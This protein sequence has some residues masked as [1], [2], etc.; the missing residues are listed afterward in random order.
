MIRH[1]W[2]LVTAAG[3]R[4]RD[5]HTIEVLGVPGELLMESAG[6]SL[7]EAVLSL[8]ADRSR[9]RV[10]AG[11]GNNGGDGLV[12]ARHLA[13]A[14]VPVRIHLVGDPARMR[15][16]AARNLERAR[17]VGLEVG[18][19]GSFAPEAAGRD[20]V[21]DAVF[22]TG[23]ARPVEGAIAEVLR[24]VGEARRAGARVVAAD[25]PSGLHADTGQPLGPVPPA[26]LTVT[27]GLPKLGLALEPGRSL[28]GRVLVARI[29]IADELPAGIGIPT[30]GEAVLPTARAVAAALPPR[31][32]EGHKGR[33]GHVLVV[34]GSPGKTGAAALAA[35]GAHRA[36][37]GLVTVACS[38]A[39]HAVLASKLTEAMT[40]PLPAGPD[41]ALGL[42]AVGPVLELAA[43]RD[44]VVLGPG[45]GRGEETVAAVRRLSAELPEAVVI[46]ADGLFALPDPG[47]LKGRR[48]LPIVT[49]HPGE[50]ARLLGLSPAEVNGDRIGAAARLAEGGGAVAL[51]KGA[52]TVSAEPGG[53]IAVNPT[54]GPVLGTG[55]TGDVLA[56]VVGGL[57]AQ[58]LDPFTAAWV[59]AYIHGLAGDA[60]ARRRGN[61]GI[62]AGE[63]ADAVPGVLRRLRRLAMTADRLPEEEGRD[64]GGAGPGPGAGEWLS[65]QGLLLPFPEPGGHPLAG[66]RPRRG[67]AGGGRG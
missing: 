4:A 10:V 47:A 23:L 28:A 57:L 38:E 1:A 13:L 51:L 18:D 65:R 25:L 67:P 39:V 54:G 61:A 9:V 44:V 53:R 62:L 2:P 34:A 42:S 43:E 45:L 48:P 27:F 59:G 50:A 29:G 35:L 21:V 33:F 26:D 60:L 55:G 22:G 24:L 6:R 41:G 12:A 3:M 5:R 40:A 36:G 7:A 19:A 30:G 15:G 37:A 63:V 14:G 52:A 64:A 46:D 20:L 8:R 31:P 58:G 17:R 11:S 16:D 66:S 56:G 49:P 32:P